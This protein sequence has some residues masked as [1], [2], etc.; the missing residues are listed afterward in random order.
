MKIK[1]DLESKIVTLETKVIRLEEKVE[2]QQALISDLIRTVKDQ[3]HPSTKSLS[4]KVCVNQEWKANAILRSCREIH[5]S[6]SLLDSGNYWIDPDGQG[7]GD[8]AINVYCNMTTGRK[9]KQ[10]IKLS[11]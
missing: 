11:E 10:L 3:Q 1:E 5:E 4:V 9:K 8:D 2:Q 7:I 6:D